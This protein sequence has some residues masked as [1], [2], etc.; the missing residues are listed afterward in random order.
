MMSKKVKIT[1]K[2]IINWF[3]LLYRQ[4]SEQVKTTTNPNEKCHLLEL[5]GTLVMFFNQRNKKRK[6][7]KNRDNS[8]ST[9]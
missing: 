4:L 5:L 1:F 7:S 9:E 3:K 8:S 2:E 6:M